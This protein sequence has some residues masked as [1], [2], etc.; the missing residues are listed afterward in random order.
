MGRGTMARQMLGGHF[1]LL[2][3]DGLPQGWNALLCLISVRHF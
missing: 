2:E 3:N 1:A